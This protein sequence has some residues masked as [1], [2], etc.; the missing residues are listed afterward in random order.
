MKN[1]KQMLA[2]GAGAAVRLVV[3]GIVKKCFHK[4]SWEQISEQRDRLT[5]SQRGPRALPHGQPQMGAG[6]W[7]KRGACPLNMLSL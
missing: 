3:L 6:D 5:Q 7:K 2:G 1:L 4:W